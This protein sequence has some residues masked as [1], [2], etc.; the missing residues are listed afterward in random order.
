VLMRLHDDSELMGRVTI[1]ADEH[2][3]AQVIRNLVSNGLKFTPANGQV[4]ITVSLFQKGDDGE[5]VLCLRLD[6]KDTG[7][8]ISEASDT[9]NV[10]SCFD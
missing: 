8:G 5:R 4:T 10:C 2:K 3:L 7:A 1:L 6:V 9:P